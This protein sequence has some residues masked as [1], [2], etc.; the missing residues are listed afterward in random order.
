MIPLIDS[1]SICRNSRQIIPSFIE[2]YSIQIT[3][4]HSV[5]RLSRI[6]LLTVPASLFLSGCAW[7]DEVGKDESKAELKLTSS[8]EDLPERF[9]CPMSQ[10]PISFYYFDADEPFEG[11]ARIRMFHS[12]VDSLY[13]NSLTLNFETTNADTLEACPKPSEFEGQ[14]FETSTNGCVRAFVQLNGCKEHEDRITAQI[15]GT[16]TIDEFSS[17]RGDRV[18]GSVQGKLVYVEKIESSTQTLEK[19]TAL[20]EVEGDFSF[21][22]KAGSIWR[23]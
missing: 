19:T 5:M 12:P 21:V 13:S 8:A 10:F 16:V 9:S 3:R 7:I 2:S 18:K 6:L 22:I 23:K 15:A 4:N 14:T 17:D 1:D 11:S 20:G